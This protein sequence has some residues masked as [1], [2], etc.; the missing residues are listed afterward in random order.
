MTLLSEITDN[1]YEIKP[2][3]KSADHF[4][5][6]TV[7]LIVD[8]KLALVETGCSVQFPDITAAIKKLGHDL[9]ELAYI[10][11]TH[12]HPDHS[13]GAG[14]FARQLPETRFVIGS[15]MA[16][17]LTDS[18]LLNRL[19]QG[20]KRLFGDDAE[21]RFGTMLPV[22]KE[23][24]ILV[25]DGDSISLGERELTVIHTPGH[26]P[27]H[28]CF[29]DKMSNGL[30]CGDALGAY[31]PEVKVFSPSYVPGSDPYLSMQSI[32]K[33]RELNPSKLFF[34]H[35]GATE[36]V[37]IEQAENVTQ[38]CMDTAIEALK[39]KKDKKEVARKLIEIFTEGSSMAGLDLSDWPYTISLIVEGYQHYLEKKT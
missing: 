37:T 33:L 2:E 13:G 25:E 9:K 24:F 6:C 39:D 3:G 1:I 22:E 12:T 29:M 30:F 28:L 38:R 18:S 32:Q 10:I 7:Y 14:H 17:I 20:W 4:P 31:F 26:D 27:C 23:R 8:D 15:G 19:M 16:T 36:E 5:L 21:D 34:S 35:G 11:P